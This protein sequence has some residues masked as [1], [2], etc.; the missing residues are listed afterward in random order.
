MITGGEMIDAEQVRATV[1]ISIDDISPHPLSS[2]KCL[3]HCHKLI[4]IFPDVKISLFIPMAYWRSVPDNR[5]GV[6][7]STDVPLFL[8]KHEELCKTLKGL[9]EKNF[10]V[11]YHGLYHGIPGVSNNL[12]FKYLNYED[13]KNILEEMLEVAS[14]AGLSNTFKKIIRPPSWYMSK[15]SIIAARDLGFE[16]LSLASEKRIRKYYDL[17]DKSGLD[18]AYYNI[19]PPYSDYPEDIYLKSNIVFHACE[20][21][22]NFLG[23]DNFDGL[24]NF[25]RLWEDKISFGF[26]EDMTQNVGKTFRTLSQE[27]EFVK[28]SLL[29]AANPDLSV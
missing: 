9:S 21:S 2:D 3:E 20:W 26:T 15:E 5:S 25:L 23:K 1:N 14:K 4:S 17:E 28:N 13:S 7:T 22:K 12:E 24:V 11:C 18:V 16:Y 29:Q 10:E 27:R 6:D 8:D 19:C